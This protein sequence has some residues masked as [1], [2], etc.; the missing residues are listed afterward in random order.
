MHRG[1]VTTACSNWVRSAIDEATQ[2]SFERCPV[3]PIFC[4]LAEVGCA[5]RFNRPKSRT[6]PLCVFGL[7]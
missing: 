1:N 6:V 2:G 3:A 7:I 5:R 4:L